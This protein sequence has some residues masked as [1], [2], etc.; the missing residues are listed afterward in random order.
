MPTDRREATTTSHRND[1]FA[2]IE[3]MLALVLVALVA[4]LVLPWAGP[5][6]GRVLLEGE[7]QRLATFLRIERNAAERAGA[8]VETRFD[9]AARTFVS[10]AG[11]GRLVLPGVLGLAVSSSQVGR[12]VFRPGGGT[13]GATFRLQS[14]GA[15]AVVAVWPHSG[16][17]EVAR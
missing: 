2:L 10:G 12:V 16:T 6:R 9:V 11:G 14:G 5:S 17:V 13:S 15:A 8:P 4:S 7:A 3:A 1:G